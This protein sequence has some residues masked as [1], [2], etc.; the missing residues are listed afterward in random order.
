MTGRE[1]R[2][3]DDQAVR[4]ADF[5]AAMLDRQTEGSNGYDTVVVDVIYDEEA[6]AMPYTAAEEWLRL[7]NGNHGQMGLAIARKTG[8][9]DTVAQ[10]LL[11]LGWGGWQNSSSSQPVYGLDLYNLHNAGPSLQSVY[12]V[13]NGE[14]AVIGSLRRM[15]ALFR[16]QVEVSIDGYTGENR[17]RAED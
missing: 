5:A 15:L 2:I 13:R 4:C 14:E 10:D 9:Y 12:G 11:L 16:G 1:N 3:L 8:R 7:H 17:L 6:I